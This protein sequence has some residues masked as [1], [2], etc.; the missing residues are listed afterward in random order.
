MTNEQASNKPSEKELVRLAQRGDKNAFARLY[1]RH[2]Q[3]VYAICFRITRERTEAE[4]C[5]QEAFLQ[6]FLRLA[7][8]RGESALST[9]LHRLAV[10]VVLMRL[11]GRR[12]KPVSL[13]ATGT[14]DDPGETVILDACSMEDVRLAGA[15]DRIALQRAVQELPCGY[16]TVFLLHDVEGKAHREIARQL[17][18]TIGTSKSQLHQAHVRLRRF[19]SRPRRRTRNKIPLEY[20]FSL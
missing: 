11:R 19:L 17:G 1:E 10:N 13:D 16:R 2:K 7:T 9:W 12:V 3:R 14:A 4:D 20:A 6:C 15:L 5:T 8:F 18:C